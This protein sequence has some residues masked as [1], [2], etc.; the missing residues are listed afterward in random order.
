CTA[1]LSDELIQRSGM[2]DRGHTEIF[3]RICRKQDLHMGFWGPSFSVVLATDHI[4][5][6]QVSRALKK[7]A[8]KTAL[9]ACG[10]MMRIL[11]ARHRSPFFVLGLNPHAGNK[12]IIGT[13]ES[14]WIQKEITSFLGSESNTWTEVAPIVPADSAFVRKQLKNKPLFLALYHDQGLIPFKMAHGFGAAVHLTLGLDFLRTSVDHG[15]AFDIFGK[16]KARPE[17]M[18]AALEFHF[19]RKV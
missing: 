5:L 7:G 8:L 4:P 15:T 19:R 11:G 16:N 6:E 12:G 1:P 17:S 3:K 14:S 9:T 18:I 10:E 13:D 2:R